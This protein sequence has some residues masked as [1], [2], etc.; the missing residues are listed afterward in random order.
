[1]MTTEEWN[2][3]PCGGN[4]PNPT[5]EA[6]EKAI[7]MCWL[8]GLHNAVATLQALSAERR[9]LIQALKDGGEIQRIAIARAEAA[10]TKL[11]EAVDVMQRVKDYRY[12][13]N[14]GI[15]LNMLETF[16]ASLEGGKP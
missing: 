3:K 16:L 6:V 2:D 5:P 11:W 15:E 10:E 14:I 8:H 13:P 9:T 12:G 1:M 4:G 7:G